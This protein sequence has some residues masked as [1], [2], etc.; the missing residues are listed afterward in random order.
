MND[1]YH[2]TSETGDRRDVFRYFMRD[3]T[4]GYLR[5]I[6]NSADHIENIHV[7]RIGP[8]K[9]GQKF[10]HVSRRSEVN[11]G[12]DRTLPDSDTQGL[13]LHDIKCEG[14]AKRRTLAA[15]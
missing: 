4:C 2:E 5:L 6:N 3:G 1:K 13:V 11:K 10:R 7:K 9:D 15:R 8:I 14:D 12:K